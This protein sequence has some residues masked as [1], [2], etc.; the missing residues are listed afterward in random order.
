MKKYLRI[1]THTKEGWAVFLGGFLLIGLINVLF[2]VSLGLFQ[3]VF[4]VAF[5]VEVI[6][7]LIGKNKPIT[8]ENK[9]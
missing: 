6:A 5:I 4:F 9:D 3:M 7:T 8:P 1:P 2:G